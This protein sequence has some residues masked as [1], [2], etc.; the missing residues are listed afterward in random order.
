ML[1]YISIRPVSRKMNIRSGN[2]RKPCNLGGILVIGRRDAE[3][4]V[5]EGIRKMWRV[6]A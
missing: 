1:I 2:A 6:Y 4:A 3:V 5:A